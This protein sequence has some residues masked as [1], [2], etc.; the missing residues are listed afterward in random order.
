L[1]IGLA[2]AA[3]LRRRQSI[4]YMVDFLVSAKLG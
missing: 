2:L 4:K 3:A 1:R